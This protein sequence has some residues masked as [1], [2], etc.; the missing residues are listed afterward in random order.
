VLVSLRGACSSCKS[1]QL[2]L[3][4]FVEKRLREA[5]EPDITVVEVR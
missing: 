3:K 5:V 2:T 1:S 4:Q